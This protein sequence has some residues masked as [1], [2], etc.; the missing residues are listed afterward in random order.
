MLRRL[1]GEDI[2]LDHDLQPDLGQVQADPGQIE[3][4]I[5]NLAV[6]ARDAMPQGGQAHH[7]DRNVDLDEEYAS[8]HAGPSTPGAP[9][10][11]GRHGQRLRHGR[12]DAGAHLRAVLHHQGAK[13]KG[14]GL[15]LSTVYGIVKQ[16]GGDIQVYSEVDKGT[17]FKVYLPRLP[18]EAE[19]DTLKTTGERPAVGHETI[20]LV[21]DEASLREVVDRM[22]KAMGYMVLKAASGSE[23]LLICQKFEGEI[24][25][26]LTD[27]VMPQMS[28][29]QLAEQLLG[30]RPSMQ[31]LFMSGYTDD[32]IV[33]HGVLDPGTQFISKPFTTA[34]LARKVRNVLDKDF[35]PGE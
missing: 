31:V 25:L 27:V 8:Q 11:A 33:H 23:A 20:L 32:A 21:E 17:S 9:C 10:D 3:Q 13:G 7:R 1:I 4:V 16:S 34:E 35:V 14:T 24:H 30:L 18:G 6:N 2:D 26:L 22:L 12:G 28:G 29:R 19:P 15:G 5:M